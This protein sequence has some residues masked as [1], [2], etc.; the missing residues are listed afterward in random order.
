[1]STQILWLSDDH[2][3]NIA[4]YLELTGGDFPD[5]NAMSYEE[6]QSQNIYYLS[7]L[8]KFDNNPT[9]AANAFNN[10]MEKASKAADD[11]C[12]KMVAHIPKPTNKHFYSSFETMEDAL[13]YEEQI[14][15]KTNKIF[16]DIMQ[17]EFYKKLQQFHEKQMDEW[18]TTH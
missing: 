6:F 14:K 7:I 8:E 3:D 15:V 16:A 17:E 11:L 18:L 10:A 4:N 2:I 13:E 12:V 9:K 5:R 1:M